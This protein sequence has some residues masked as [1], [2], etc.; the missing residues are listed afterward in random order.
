MDKYFFNKWLSLVLDGQDKEES[1]QVFNQL[2]NASELKTLCRN[3]IYYNK[4]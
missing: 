2:H 4:L 3:S 1:L